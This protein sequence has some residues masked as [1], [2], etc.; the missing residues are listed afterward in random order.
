MENTKTNIRDALAHQY[1][2]PLSGLSE[3]FIYHCGEVYRARVER[4][5]FR[6]IAVTFESFLIGAVQRA[7]EGA[8]L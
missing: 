1:C 8:Y 7:D 2:N 5:D 6:N 4:G 3:A